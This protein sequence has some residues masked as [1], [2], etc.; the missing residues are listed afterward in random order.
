MSDDH[1]MLYV[2]PFGR[3]IDIPAGADVAS[4]LDAH[5]ARPSRS[6]REE[7][8]R[9]AGTGDH[10]GAVRGGRPHPFGAAA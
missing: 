6:D 2:P 4:T 9:E 1:A 5:E 8:T 7:A 10:A 3:P